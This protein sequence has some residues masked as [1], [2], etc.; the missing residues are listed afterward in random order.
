MNLAGIPILTSPYV[1]KAECSEV[2]YSRPLIVRLFHGRTV[3]LRYWEEDQA[4]V[5]GGDLVMRP[6][7]FGVMRGLT[8]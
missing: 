5:L 6:E 3:D 4:F 2:D 8:P 7:T 1:P